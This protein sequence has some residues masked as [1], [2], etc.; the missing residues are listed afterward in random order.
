MAELSRLP[1]PVADLWEWQYQGACR[2]ATTEQFFHPQGERGAS[3]RNRA[4]RAKAICASCPVMA[5]CRSHA[6]AVREPYGVWGGLTEEER[7]A[8]YQRSKKT[9]AVG[10]PAAASTRKLAGIA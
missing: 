6:L 5:E 1:G 2:E 8:V 10:A 9:A 4:A 3:R 7:E